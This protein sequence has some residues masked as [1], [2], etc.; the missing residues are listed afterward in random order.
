[1]NHQL[2]E[3]ACVIDRSGSMQSIADDAVG[4]FNA[5]LAA[6]KQDPSPARLSLVLFDHE[7]L[8]LHDGLPLA[9]VP[10]LDR[11]S[12]VPRG[13]T[14][15]LDAIGRTIDDLG[16][17]LAATPEAD[18]PGKVLVAILTDGEEN[19]SRTYALEQIRAMI[20]HQQAKY[21][22][23]FVYLGANQDAIKTAAKMAISAQTSMDFSASTSGMASAYTRMSAEVSRARSRPAPP[24]PP[25]AN[26]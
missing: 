8:V 13:M 26:E 2:T 22:W 16:K 10:P 3:I 9:D 11:T 20:S 5:F 12:Y 25:D 4:G 21:A 15:L 14:A 18:R 19:S 23:E 6:Q 7:Y 24:P 17:R 1:M